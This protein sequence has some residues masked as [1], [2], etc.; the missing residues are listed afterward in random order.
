LVDPSLDFWLVLKNSLDSLESSSPSG[1]SVLYFGPFFVVKVSLSTCFD[2]YFFV[3]L[4]DSSV[5][6]IVVDGFDA[7]FFNVVSW[8]LQK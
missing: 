2:D 6:D 4:I 5:D 1:Y 7:P 3:N 8:D